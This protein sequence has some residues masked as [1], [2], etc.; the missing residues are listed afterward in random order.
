MIDD[1]TTACK[2]F[3]S[4]HLHEVYVTRNFGKLG[5]ITLWL[6]GKS[7][8]YEICKKQ[9]HCGS[10]KTNFAFLSIQLKD[11]ILQEAFL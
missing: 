2:Y 9:F 7:H 5:N 6:G 3:N 11:F 4:V 8:L 1:W 10:I